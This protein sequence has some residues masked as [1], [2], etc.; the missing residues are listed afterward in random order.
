MAKADKWD[1]KKFE[2]GKQ[3]IKADKLEKQ[4]AKKK[5]AM[6]KSGGKK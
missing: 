4:A 2:G 1:S 3:D 5:P 6:K